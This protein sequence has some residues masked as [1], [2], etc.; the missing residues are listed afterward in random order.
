MFN[1]GK[2]S[3]TVGVASMSLAARSN[4]FAQSVKATETSDYKRDEN[5]FLAPPS[6]EQMYGSAGSRMTG[7]C[8]RP[9][10]TKEMG[11]NVKLLIR[12]LIFLS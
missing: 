1:I 3:K 9:V 7:D 12:R 5:R 8:N 4:I 2:N 10:Q 11:T 6:S